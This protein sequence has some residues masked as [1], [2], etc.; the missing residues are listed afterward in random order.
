M[1][2]GSASLGE[3]TSEKNNK[4]MWEER[5]TGPA[6]HRPVP[7]TD[8]PY[9]GGMGRTRHIRLV[10][11]R[12]LRRVHRSAAAPPAPAPAARPRKQQQQPEP[13]VPRRIR[14][15]RPC[16]SPSP[17]YHRPRDYYIHCRSS[18]TIAG[19]SSSISAL[20][21]ASEF[22]QKISR[23]ITD[24][25]TAPEAGHTHPERKRGGGER[26]RACR[27]LTFIY[28]EGFS[29]FRSTLEPAPPS[30]AGHCLRQL[31]VGNF[32]RSLTRLYFSGPM[33]LLLLGQLGY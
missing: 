24:V 29:F 31:R 18:P 1:R 12:H 23:H 3:I 20:A 5:L 4:K 15:R 27:V 17:H 2:S 33:G 25:H 6:G 10:G 19:P 13:A 9:G 22:C 7:M 30:S 11:S 8:S 32:K 14:D 16:G 26:E 21:D 28:S